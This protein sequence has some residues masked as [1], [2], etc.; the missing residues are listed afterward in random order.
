M[1]KAMQVEREYQINEAMETPSYDLQSLYN[2]DYNQC[3]SYK[4]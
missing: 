3:F 4:N 2:Q 1:L